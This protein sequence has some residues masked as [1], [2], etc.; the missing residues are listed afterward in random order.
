MELEA[1]HQIAI[2]PN[3]HEIKKKK[4]QLKSSAAFNA[5]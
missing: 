3:L 1:I 2:V 5:I 4:Q